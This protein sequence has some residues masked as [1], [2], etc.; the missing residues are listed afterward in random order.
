MKAFFSW[1]K[2][3]AEDAERVSSSVSFAVCVLFFAGTL[4]A[5]T[6]FRF[7][8]KAEAEQE[9][10]SEPSR[11]AVKLTDFYPEPE[12]VQEEVVPEEEPPPPPPPVP[13]PPPDPE[14]LPEKIDETALREIVE[15]LPETPPPPP[16]PPKEEPPPEPE[17]EP[18]PPEPVPAPQPPPPPPPVQ[19]NSAQLEV[20]K[21][22][23][24]QTLYGA[25]ADAVRREKF[26]PRAARRNGRTGT[27]SL[28]VEIAADGTIADFELMPGSAHSSLK[29]GAM[30]TLRKVADDFVAPAST[31]AALP[32]TFIVPVVYELK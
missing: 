24:E 8:L 9:C 32:A 2:K 30:K 25:L 1:L 20:A 7:E 28:R 22:T 5:F 10:I 18:L 6:D 12:P 11:I 26:Y 19:D 4:V 21:R 13:E 31:A 23:A 27:V 3:S 14:P 15:P 29:N 17:P 16:E